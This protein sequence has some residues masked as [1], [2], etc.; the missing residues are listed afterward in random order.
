[1]RRSKARR[2]RRSFTI[3]VS[4]I[5]SAVSVSQPK[6]PTLHAYKP[7]NADLGACVVTKEVQRRDILSRVVKV[8]SAQ[9]GLRVTEVD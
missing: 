4:G 1:M 3:R 9:Q 2:A 5:G 8:E 7:E 6:L